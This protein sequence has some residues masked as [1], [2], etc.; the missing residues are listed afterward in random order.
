MRGG[1]GCGV[2]VN[3]SSCAHGAQINF[4]DLA[5]Y[6]T[7]DANLSSFNCNIVILLNQCKEK[8]L[9]YRRWRVTKAESIVCARTGSLEYLGKIYFFKNFALGLYRLDK[10]LGPDSE[11]RSISDRNVNTGALLIA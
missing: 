4:G 1:R 7:Y 8:A 3:E 5:P 2:S 9:T 11:R 6:L 10:D